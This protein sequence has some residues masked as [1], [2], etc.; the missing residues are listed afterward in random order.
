MNPASVDPETKTF[1]E[2]LQP[3]DQFT[4]LQQTDVY[5]LAAYGVAKDIVGQI[6]DHRSNREI[7]PR[8]VEQERALKSACDL[9][10]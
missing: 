3:K 7:N 8:V 5:D 4:I 2:N 1:L 6:K 10:G 9:L